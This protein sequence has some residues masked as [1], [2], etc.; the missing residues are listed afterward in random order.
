[1][2]SHLRGCRVE[3]KLCLKPGCPV[4]L[5]RN[6]APGLVNGLRGTV[7][8]TDVVAPTVRFNNG[9]TCVM[10]RQQFTSD[11]QTAVREQF[12]LQL[13]YA[14]TIHRAQGQTIK[15][16]VVSCSGI[17][18]PGQLGVAI[19]RAVSKHGL[20]VLNYSEELGKISPSP[21]V[22]D[23]YTTESTFP[24]RDLSCCRDQS[25]STSTSTD[26]QVKGNFLS[27]L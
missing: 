11:D 1:M 20:Q 8:K 16:L 7:V 19:G 26:L 10:V 24:E 27:L 6:I 23:Y 4:I 9:K 18:R 17:F 22:Y 14:L 13:A 2:P 12:P 21:E 15:N 3:R 25:A 5:L